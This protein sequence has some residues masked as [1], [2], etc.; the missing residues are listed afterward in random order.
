[1]FLQRLFNGGIRLIKTLMIG[2]WLKN[3]C[4][5]KSNHPTKFQCCN[6]GV[7]PLGSNGNIN[8]SRTPLS[9]YIFFVNNLQTIKN[10]YL[11]S[12]SGLIG[13]ITGCS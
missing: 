3:G 9:N 8:F 10:T 12:L 5:P 11:Y 2:F 7:C 4:H 13:F 1:M 6:N